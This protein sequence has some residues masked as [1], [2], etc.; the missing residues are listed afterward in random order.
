MT[1]CALNP[2]KRPEVREKIRISKLGNTF[3]RRNKGKKH[4]PMSE[5]TRRKISLALKGKK[6]G[7]EHRR[8]CSLAKIGHNFTKEGRANLSFGQKLRF[9]KV[10]ER[11][12]IAIASIKRWNTLSSEERDAVVRPL[13]E[14]T[15]GW[16]NKP[17]EESRRKAISEGNKRAWSKMTPER[18]KEIA[19]KALVTAIGRGSMK[20]PKIKPNK[21]EKN[22]L[23]LLNTYFPKEWKY[24]GNGEI[25]IGNR[26]PDFLN[27]NGEKSVIELF[28]NYWH[29]KDNAEQRIRHYSKYGFKCLVIWESEMKD[30]N[31]IN[32][33]K[34]LAQASLQAETPGN[35]A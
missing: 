30:I 1:T 32:K 14:F 34:Q 10:E 15:I 28:G 13:L 17:H 18:R 12:K 23:N 6:L 20:R 31:V 11:E 22:L 35:S 21:P 25:W 8:N 27:V 2:A 29:K 4:P 26:N 9:S 7:E 24:T 19:H 3:G 5:E 16:S 33:I